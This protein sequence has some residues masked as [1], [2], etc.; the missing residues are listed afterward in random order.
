MLR[1]RA[2]VPSAP[3]ASSPTAATT[4]F[5]CDRNRPRRWLENSAST[6]VS[7]IFHTT[8]FLLLALFSEGGSGVAGRVDEVSIGEFSKTELVDLPTESL[9]VEAVSAGDTSPAAG[10]ALEIAAPLA[11]SSGSSGGGLTK[12]DD[13]ALGP[14]TLS[15]GESA[16]FDLGSLSV[17]GG[18]VGGGNWEGMIQTLR[19]DG[20]DIVL[21]FDSTGSMAG[22]IGV[23]KRQIGRIGATLLKLIPNARISICTYRDDGDA[24]VVIGMPLSS[25]IQEVQAY[26]DKINADGGG[27]EPEAVQEGLRWSMAYNTFR[28]K[29]RKVILLFGDAP[30]HAHHLQTCLRLASD[31]N[32]SNKGIRQHRHLPAPAATERIRRNRLRGR[33]RS[34][35]DDRRAS[36]HDAIDRTGIRQPA[37]GKSPGGISTPRAQ[38]A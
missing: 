33:R 24:Y 8:L 6:L 29:A 36:D 32:Q 35:P 19:R 26:L 22:E 34:V 14:P 9:Q 2:T 21:T 7:L 10:E 38:I 11:R 23:V 31:F 27:D 25:D 17:G 15:G 5:D 4:E 13:L 18:S 30:P 12:Y 28:P 3:T 20:L 1:N 37:P 16:T